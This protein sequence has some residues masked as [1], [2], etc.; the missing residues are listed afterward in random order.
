[1]ELREQLMKGTRS[2]S[3]LPYIGGDDE[4]GQLLELGGEVLDEAE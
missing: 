1:V 4:D 2:R 3:L